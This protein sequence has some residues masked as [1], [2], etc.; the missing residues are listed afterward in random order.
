LRS[1]VERIG[2]LSGFDL[3]ESLDQV[4]PLCLGEPDERGL[5]RF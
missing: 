2:T 3:L 1:P 5:L 4:E